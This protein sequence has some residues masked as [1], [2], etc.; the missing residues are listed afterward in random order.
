MEVIRRR[1]RAGPPGRGKEAVPG[2]RGVTERV[3]SMQGDL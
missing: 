3:S 2:S 1:N